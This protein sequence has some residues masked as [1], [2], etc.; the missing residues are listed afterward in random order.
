MNS[1]EDIFEKEF[2]EAQNNDLRD[3]D[4]KVTNGKSLKLA[5]DYII[6]VIGEISSRIEALNDL[7][8]YKSLFFETIDPENKIFNNIVERIKGLGAKVKRV[9]DFINGYLYQETIADSNNG[10]CDFRPENISNSVNK[11]TRLAQTVVRNYEG[12]L[13]VEIPCQVYNTAINEFNRSINL[14]NKQR[15]FN[16]PQADILAS[17][18]SHIDLPNLALI[19]EIP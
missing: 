14:L 9:C 10:E 8:D 16:I 5:F 12:K 7:N 11:N 2:R 15:K 1:T 17:F 18:P 3:F 6:N 19:K 4:I 13:S